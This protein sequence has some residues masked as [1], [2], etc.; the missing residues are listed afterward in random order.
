MKSVVS[1]HA[2]GPAQWLKH[3]A[4]PYGTATGLSCKEHLFLADR[5]LLALLVIGTSIMAI[6]VLGSL[7]D[8][9]VRGVGGGTRY[10]VQQQQKPGPRPLRSAPPQPGQLTWHAVT[11]DTQGPSMATRHYRQRRTSTQLLP[12]AWCIDTH[13]H[14]TVAPIQHYLPAGI[15]SQLLTDQLVT[16]SAQ[17]CNTAD[18]THNLPTPSPPIDDEPLLINFTRN[19]NR[20]FSAS[21][22][23]FTRMRN[24]S[25]ELHLLW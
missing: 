21:P 9:R 2:P 3:S 8:G 17:R 7:K 4:G 6:A 13:H 1:D 20:R 5:Q 24:F 11:D 19:L 14:H 15:L 25:G 22:R 16:N 18:Y 10:R 23:G 12:H